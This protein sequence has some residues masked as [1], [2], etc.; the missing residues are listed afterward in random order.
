MLSPPSWGLSSR[1]GAPGWGSR[2]RGNSP[3]PRGAPVTPPGPLG[4]QL[5]LL[6]LTCTEFVRSPSRGSTRREQHAGQHA[7]CRVLLSGDE[8]PAPAPMKESGCSLGRWAPLDMGRTQSDRAALPLWAKRLRSEFQAVVPGPPNPA[9]DSWV[10]CPHRMPFLPTPRP[11]PSL[12]SLVREES[13]CRGDPGVLPLCPS[14]RAGNPEHPRGQGGVTE[15]EQQGE[16]HRLQP[17]CPLAFPLTRIGAR[18]AVS[19][20]VCCL[21]RLGAQAEGQECTQDP[22]APPCG[23]SG[24]NPDRETTASLHLC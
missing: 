1:E 13:R 7:G 4:G 17:W 3:A 21:L 11:W 2:E 9:Q 24:L 20:V 8:R 23:V 16:G 10:L 22:H 12:C 5:P 14:V 6:P 18:P 15:R 19:T